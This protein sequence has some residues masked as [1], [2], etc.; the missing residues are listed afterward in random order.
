[1]QFIEFLGYEKHIL[2]RIGTVKTYLTETLSG[3]M[4]GERIEANSFD[5]AEM[6]CPDGYRVIGFL[7][8][9]IDAPEFDGWNLN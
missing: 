5:E 9:E 7:V 1:M 6:K 2:I 3:L 8:E 4:A